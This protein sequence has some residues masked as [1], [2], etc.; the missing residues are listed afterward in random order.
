[1]IIIG[2][3]ENK[4]YKCYFTSNTD[5]IKQYCDVRKKVYMETFNIADF[6]SHEDEY[7]YHKNTRILVVTLDDK[8]IGGARLTFHYAGENI[9]LP[10]EY[11]DFQLFNLFPKLDLKKKN[12]ME[13]T[14]MA[15]LP[16]Y[17]RDRKM[18]SDMFNLMFTRSVQ[19]GAECMYSVTP[20]IQCRN[21]RRHFK[22]LGYEMKTFDDIIVIDK[23]AYDGKQMFLSITDIHNKLPIGHN[24]IFYSKSSVSKFEVVS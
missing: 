7:D 6:T 15:T 21:N 18:A 2:E 19:E 13:I 8:V 5:L 20:K 3:V 16:E 14:R 9:K 12:Y 1:M 11:D 24:K 23:P 17:R 4:E 22:S 10:M